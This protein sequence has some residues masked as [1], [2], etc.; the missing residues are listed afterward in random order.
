MKIRVLIVDDEPLAREKIRDL[1]NNEDHF[2]TIG[3]AANGLEAVSAVKEKSPDLVFL[4]VQMPELNG[5]GVVEKLNGKNI[6]QII[7]VTAY[8]EYA[9]QAFKVHALDYLLKPFDQDRFQDAI[10]RARENIELKKNS[11]FTEKLRELL[12]DVAPGEK[13]LDRLI[14]KSGGRIFFIQT[15]KIDWIEAADNYVTVHTGEKEYL[16]RDTMSNMEKKLS[17]EKFI[18]V[19]RSSIVNIE[20]IKEI[21]PWF[22][23]EYKILLK[24][25]TKL[26]LSRKYRENLKRFF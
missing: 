19:H 1:L 4:D 3:E 12:Q 9:L 8:D 24:D 15:E 25:D 17:P 22:N 2:E 16:V 23:H 6:P 14:V 13:Y 18:R 11:D 20:Q 10:T 7:F 26:T 5:F 21:Q